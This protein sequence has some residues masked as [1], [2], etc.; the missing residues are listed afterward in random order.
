MYVHGDIVVWSFALAA[1]A[2]L[3]TLWVGLRSR[4]ATELGTALTPALLVNVIWALLL[5]ADARTPYLGAPGHYFVE[6]LRFGGW[7]A[8]MWVMLPRQAKNP[9]LEALPRLLVAFWAILVL[10]G[11]AV[12]T[13]MDLGVIR[14]WPLHLFGLGGLFLAVLVMVS[15][16]QVGR[17]STDAGYW[18]F[19]H[20]LTGLGLTIGYD[21]VMFSTTYVFADVPDALW[22]ARG[23]ANALATLPMMYGIRRISR[24]PVDRRVGMGGIFFTTMMM[25]AGTYLFLVAL[26]AAYVRGF[27]GSWGGALEVVILFG[28]F[29]FLMV[30]GFSAEARAVIRVFIQKYFVAQK[31]DYREEWLRFV[32]TLDGEQAAL[33][34]VDLGRRVVRALAAITSSPDGGLWIRDHDN[35]QFVP[36]VGR[37][38]AE[39]APAF[40]DE[41]TPDHW[42]EMLS[43]N[44]WILDVDGMFPPGLSRAGL[45]EWLRTH[46][47]VWLVVPLTVVGRIEGFVVLEPPLSADRELNWEDFDL[48]RTAATQA[49]GSLALQRALDDIGQLEQFEA[50]NRLAAF[51][52]H[53]LKNVLAQ[54][55]LVVRNFPRFRDNPE[56]IDDAILTVENATRRME[57]LIEQLKSGTTTPQRRRF[58]FDESCREALSAVAGRAPRPQV[59]KLPD[60]SIAGDPERFRSAITHL[61]RNA[62]DATPAD[63]VIKLN[64]SYEEGVVS[65]TIED[66]GEGMTDEF[67]RERLFK[68]FDS[69]KGVMGMGV[70]AYQAREYIRELGGELRV[71]SRPQH[72]TRFTLSIPALV[73]DAIGELAVGAA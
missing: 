64:A 49:A 5:T 35:D 38:C 57:R 27:S 32:R 21:I 42:M 15:A 36:V 2:L 33:D 43:Q 6:M 72:G 19:K 48:L 1:L 62:Q 45:P 44:N 69:T 17:N 7:M 16:E 20:L 54:Q 53:D 3:V 65:L 4:L 10:T 59:G 14:E 41:R 8:L 46:R 51:L 31:Y 55:Q 70:G 25:L 56:F 26:L 22:Q 34:R 18:S 73:V 61:L 24:S 11:A 67:I 66:S 50:F 63:G 60:V 71:S 9:W 13:A 52:M 40:I 29:S 39:G 37:L 30:V 28:G 23:F 12:A 68:P 58:R 47:S